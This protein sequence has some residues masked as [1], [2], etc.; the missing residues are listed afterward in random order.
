MVPIPPILPVIS[1]SLDDLV[2]SDFELFRNIW[3]TR[4]LISTAVVALGLLFELPEICHESAD[5]IRALRHKPRLPEIAPWMKLLV[6][7]GWLLIVVGVTGEFVADSFVSK[8]DGIVQAFDE[9]LIADAQRQTELAKIRAGGAYERAAQTEKEA[10]RLREEAEAEH[11]ARVKIEAA[12]AWRELSERDKQDIGRAV[13][14]FKSLA[15][16]SVWFNASSTEAETFADD[17]AEALRSG[18]IIVQPPSGIME[19]RES[20][21]FGESVKPAIT[22]VIVQSTKDD[23]ASKFAASLIAELTSRGFDAVRQTD[24][25]FSEGKFP[26]IW[27]NV[28][29]RPRGPQGE[30]KLQ[31]ERDAGHKNNA[32]SSRPPN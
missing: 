21:K 8:A 12:V 20:G 7:I 28:E 24:P 5:A 6:S 27:V 29:P 16:A 11:L 19:M 9:S 1:K 15:A 32:Q 18:Q 25:P 31:A 26:Q 30:Y 23:A 3:F 22:G 13:T 4:L 14:G 10:A 2:R 17:I